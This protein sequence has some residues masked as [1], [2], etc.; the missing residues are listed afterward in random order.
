MY[1]VDCSKYYETN[2]THF[3]INVKI[4]SYRSM[5]I[6]DNTGHIRITRHAEKYVNSFKFRV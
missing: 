3:V 4:I 5:K 1:I 2:D 6:D